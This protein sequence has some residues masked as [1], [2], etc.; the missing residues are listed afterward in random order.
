MNVAKL[1]Y[2]VFGVCL[3]S[4]LSEDCDN[5]DCCDDSSWSGTPSGPVGTADCEGGGF[6]EGDCPPE[7][8][9]ASIFSLLSHDTK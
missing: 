9:V 3:P 7:T 1:R 8:N 2:P 6:N 4:D 5:V